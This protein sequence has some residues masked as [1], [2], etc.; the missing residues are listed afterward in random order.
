M[1]ENDYSPPMTSNPSNE[2]FWVVGDS[3]KFIATGEETSGQYDL[4][5]AYVPPNVGTT[6]HIH[7]K[8]DEGFY[9]VD[10]EVEF[11]LDDE[12]ITATAGTFVNV[13]KGHIHA[14]RNLGTEPARMLVQGI[15]SGLDKLIE[16]TSLPYSDPATPPPS[17]EL[18]DRVVE[19]FAQNDSVAPNDLIFANTEFSVNEDGTP[20]AAVTVFRPLDDKGTVGATINLSDGTATNPNNYNVTQIP[21]NFADGERIKTVDIPIVDNNLI[22][23]NKTINLTLSD[24]TGGAII[25]LLQDTATLTIVDDDARPSG[26]NGVPIVGDDSDNVLE[27]GEES[28]NITG[29]KG[30]DTLAGGGNQDLFTVRLGDGIDTIADFGGVGTGAN[31]SADVAAEID[32]LKFEGAGLTAKNMIL[33]QDGSGL[34]ITFE[35]VDN[36]GVRLQ[37]FPSENLENLHTTTGASAD[38]GN[39]LFDGQKGFQDSFDIFN[40]NQQSDS[41]FNPNSVTFLNDLDNNTRGFDNSNDVINSQG[42]NDLL[43]GLS[44]DDL[45]RGGTGDDTLVGG[46]GK[47]TLI[48]GSGSDAF[49]FSPKA[50]ID[51]IADFTN[52]EDL[53]GLSGG[54]SFDD[55]MIIQGTGGSANDTLINIPSSNE[56]LAI[57]NGVQASALA[58]TDFSTI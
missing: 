30:N 34:L 13:P 35:E 52:D 36:T 17:D 58:S 9:I 44:G 18:L 31:P 4:F 19:A 3:V 53:I 2:S 55:L 41:V 45:L 8:Q 15:P 50:G 23:G 14:Y 51:I 49:L 33:T 20:I 46:F 57:L 43:E 7:L 6:P 21:V 42:G 32:T 54:L 25:G 1:A 40:A 39:V 37:D 10:G 16:E 47:D 26:E 29:G 11:Q 48:G 24:P 22:E 27:G 28:D 5:D 38:I 56:L 12:T